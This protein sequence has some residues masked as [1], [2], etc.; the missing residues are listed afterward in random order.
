MPLF[1]YKAIAQDGQIQFGE[2]DAP[3]RAVVISRL[4]ST[5]Q[6]PIS[7][8]E[9]DPRRYSLGALKNRFKTSSRVSSRDL[10]VLTRELATLLQAGLPLDSALQTLVRL[11]SSQALKVLVTDIHNRVRE[12]M[13]LSDAMNHQGGVFNRLYLNMIRAGEAG[14]AMH[15]VIDRIADY[16][17]RMAELRSTIITALLYPC[18]LLVVSLLSLLILMGVVVPRFVPLFAD[19]GQTLPLLTRMVFGAAALFQSWWWALLGGIALSIWALDKYLAG[20]EHHLRFDIWLLGL[21]QIGALLQQV[22]IA[23]FSRTLGTL[24]N[25]GVP[26]LTAITLVR[27]VIANRAMSGVMDQVASSLEQG[28][29][30]AQP[31]KDSGFYPPLAVQ[32]IEVGEESGQLDEMLLRVADIYDREAQ[33]RVKRLLTLLEPVLI[34]GLGGVIAVII[35]SILMAMLGLND[36]VI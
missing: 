20:A 24:L 30:L 15:Q 9:S 31:L 4:Q 6:L 18:I 25:N 17:E 1:R 19:A 36:L 34:L 29:R 26:V 12:G 33:A 2:M 35:I 8:E 23:R 14:G 21:P 5:G 32:L 16:L 7:A 13:S 10:V 3:S 22:D 27:E 11:S 28:Q